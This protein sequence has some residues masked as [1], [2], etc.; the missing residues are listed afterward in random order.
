MYSVQE[1]YVEI[2]K[3]ESKSIGPFLLTSQLQGVDTHRI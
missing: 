2:D 3:L 1:C